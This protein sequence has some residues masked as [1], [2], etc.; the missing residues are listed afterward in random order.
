MCGIAGFANAEGSIDSLLFER[1]AQRI[2][3]RGPDDFGY[4]YY[5]E[6]NVQIS[7]GLGRAKSL[8]S[9][10]LASRRLA[11]LDLGEQGWQPM[12]SSDG[13]YYIIF[14]GEIYNYLELRRQLEAMGHTF[15]SQCDTE[16]L[17]TGFSQ[18]RKDVLTRLVGMFAFA[19]LDT[20]ERSLF[21]ARDF[22][23]IKP[24]Y[25]ATWRAGIVFSSEIKS[26]MELP[27]LGRHA[28]P[29]NIYRYLRFG[30]SDQG[31]DT[32]LEEIRQIPAGHFMEVPLDHP[33]AAN[34]RCYWKPSLDRPL[35]ISF[36]DAANK[37]RELFLESMS[38]H[39]RSDVPVG[40]ALSGGIDSSSIA[41]AMRHLLGPKLEVHAFSFIASDPEI[42]EERW[43]D[44]LGRST[45]AV[46]HKV[47]AKPEEL[48]HD[49]DALIA[50]QDE[51]F[52]STS[53]Y[54]QYRVFQMAHEK[55]IKVM[56]D[57]QGAD[58][59]LGGYQYFLAARLASLVRQGNW[60][61]AA[62]FLRKSSTSPGIGMMWLLSRSADHLLPE[63]LKQ[64]ARRAIGRDLVPAW[65]DGSWFAD[66]GIVPRSAN[67]RNGHGV[68][69]H[70]LLE[71]L[72]DTS[73]PHLLRYEDRN[74]MNF[75][76]ESRVPFLTPR[77][78]DFMLSL[79]E[80]YVVAPDGTSKA[81]F[82]KAMRGI[83]PDE[84][85]NRRDKI[86]FATPERAWLNE[87][88][89]W[90]E[91]CLTSDSVEQVPALSRSGMMNEWEEVRRGHR[92][93]GTHVWRWINL[94]KWSQQQSVSYN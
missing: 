22:F 20:K 29:R 41:A 87:L 80:Q 67:G 38:L 64:V 59:I 13:R 73:L 82:R 54:A 23:G 19:I 58:E 90:V 85:L 62:A 78:V 39:L 42:N 88:R 45:G 63:N 37:V 11:I 92:R 28:N 56:L 6:G 25:Y 44:L 16:V 86:G 93:F 91:Q 10:A 84:I 70:Q 3:H 68:L 75:S 8:T 79:P 7:R 36:D 30:E 17:L 65:M 83:V 4:L 34:P 14:N 72:T 52:G 12:R 53:I 71:T 61:G 76:I 51:P 2:D 27:G 1:I 74:S 94:I 57:G 66:R 69:R 40:V 48:E 77:L 47:R 89:P 21:L 60:T 32:L 81:V 35:D 33:F 24:L 15:R 55:G 5:S 9:C 26:L 18:W 50:S 49:L 43:I 31:G 46:I